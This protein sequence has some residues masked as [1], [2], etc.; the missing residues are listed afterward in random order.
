MESARQRLFSRHG[1]ENIQAFLMAV[2]AK[3]WA[4]KGYWATR[5]PEDGKREIRQK[6]IKMNKSQRLLGSTLLTVAAVLANVGL[7]STAQAGD[8]SHTCK[9]CY[10]CDYH[11]KAP[12]TYC[13]PCYHA[14]DYCSKYQQPYC[15]P[16]YHYEYRDYRVKTPYTCYDECGHAY[17]AYRYENVHQKIKVDD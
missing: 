17:T 15:P 1:D 11:A 10:T 7:Q 2:Q 4:L 13:Q 3:R 5:S 6:G 8:Y 9:P 16:A 12:Q 14:P